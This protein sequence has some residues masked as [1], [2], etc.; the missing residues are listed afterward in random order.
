MTGQERI[1][2]AAES[3][4]IVGFGQRLS[5]MQ[6]A[7]ALP[8]FQELIRTWRADGR[9]KYAI[10]R[11]AAPFTSGTPTY[12]LGPGSTWDTGANVPRPSTITYAYRLDGDTEVPIDVWSEQDW[13]NEPNKLATSSTP[14]AV[15][16]YESAGPTQSVRV[17]PE[18]DVSGNLVLA[19]KGALRD[20]GL[21]DNVVFPELYDRAFR[22]E[23]MSVLA[24][25]FNRTL[26]PEQI[27]QHTIAVTELGAANLTLPDWSSAQ[28]ID[29]YRR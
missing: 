27:T 25:P 19:F 15:V 2:L 13:E 5:P 24:V 3:L 16:S 18:P 20:Y 28:F 4:N 21:T 8:Y 7:R 23:L 26:T 1:R 29:P 14:K 9:F 10:Q 11:V 6:S 12:T 22:L 17:W